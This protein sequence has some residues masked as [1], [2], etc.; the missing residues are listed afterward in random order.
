[1]SHFAGETDLLV[2]FG[3]GRRAVFV[4]SVQHPILASL[5]QYITAQVVTSVAPV[6]RK[7][8][9]TD[10][11]SIR[12]I[13]NKALQ[14]LNE[15]IIT[16]PKN[17]CKVTVLITRHCNDYGVYAMDDGESGDKHCSFVGYERTEYF[18]MKFESHTAQSQEEINRRW[19]MPSAL[20]ALLPEQG[21]Q[22]G[23]INYR[24]I[25]M[26]LPLA[27]RTNVPIQVVAT[28]DQVGTSIREKLQR[29]GNICGQVMV[30]AWKHR[31]IPDV[32]AALGCGPDQGCYKS[33]PDE[34]FD[35]VWQLRFIYEPPA[36]KDEVLRLLDE[37]SFL[38]QDDYGILAQQKKWQ[39]YL[40]DLEGK[41]DSRYQHPSANTG[42]TVYGGRT[43][44]EFDPLQSEYHKDTI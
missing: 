29:N 9:S 19:P 42:W 30:V 43:N 37:D 25:E 13:A 16:V 38:L 18:A 35:Q 7:S 21:T 27:K 3:N 11:E 40:L 44:Q 32:A 6:S 12:D 39:E 4:L 1:M 2:S 31:F 24:Q 8:E 36:P 5:T 34:E 33:Y 41:R 22:N 17:E 14:A 26:L 28:A 23:G 20:Y 15:N 10:E